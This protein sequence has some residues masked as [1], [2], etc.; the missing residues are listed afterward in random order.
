MRH[1][2][3]GMGTRGGDGRVLRVARGA[4]EVDQE[5]M[6]VV[7]VGDAEGASG[8]TDGPGGL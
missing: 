2:E 5:L 4:G 8:W 3:L 6:S 1:R 7:L